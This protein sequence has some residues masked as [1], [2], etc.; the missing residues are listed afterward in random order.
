VPGCNDERPYGFAVE[1]V[2]DIYI[3]TKQHLIREVNYSTD[4]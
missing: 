1:P 3:A 2:G 4:D